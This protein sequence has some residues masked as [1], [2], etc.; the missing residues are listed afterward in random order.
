MNLDEN[1]RAVFFALADTLIPEAEGMPRASEAGNIFFWVDRTLELRPELAEPTVLGLRLCQGKAPRQALDELSA[2]HPASY[3]AIGY[4]TAAAYL[5]SEDVRR[6][7]GYPGQER[8]QFD[9]DATPEY[10]ENGMLQSVID[11]GPIYR[12]TSP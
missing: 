11:R 8:R 5:M 2:S 1:A 3:E 12:P 7:L 9:P 4:V 10:V 6:R